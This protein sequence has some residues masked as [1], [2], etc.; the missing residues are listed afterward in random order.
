MQRTTT[1]RRRKELRRSAALSR[2]HLLA[3]AAALAGR[4]TGKATFAQLEQGLT[5]KDQE[6]WL[7]A[8]AADLVAHKGHALVVAGAHLPAEV[9][10]LVYALNIALDAVGN[11]IDFVAVPAPVTTGITDVAKLLDSGSVK[12]LVILGGNPAYN[13]PADLNFAAAIK[14]A[15]QVVRLGYHV[16]ETSAAAPSGAHLAAAA[17]GVRPGRGRVPAQRG[18]AAAV[19]HPAGVL[20]DGV[21]R[22]RSR[23]AAKGGLA[24]GD[25]RGPFPAAGGGH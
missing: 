8:C 9:H 24:V 7:A 13:A 10:A 1:R 6:K 18:R 17:V 2:R 21:G 4:I 11:T 19:V 15:G 12:S 23:G 3:F 22:P 25:V 14:K 5:F 20:R 16:D